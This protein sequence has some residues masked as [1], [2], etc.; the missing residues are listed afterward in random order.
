MNTH[1]LRGDHWKRLLLCLSLIAILLAV[2]IVIYIYLGSHRAL[3][4]SHFELTRRWQNTWG[5]QSGKLQEVSKSGDNLRIGTAYLF[6]PF[7]IH[8]WDASKR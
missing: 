4:V 3:T 2:P 7:E 5:F 1:A 6:G 8:H